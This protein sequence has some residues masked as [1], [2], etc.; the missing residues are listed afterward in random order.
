MPRVHRKRESNN[1]DLRGKDTLV[2][3]LGASWCPYCVYN[4]TQQRYECV[5]HRMCVYK[6]S[7][8]DYWKRESV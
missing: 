4:K 2:K 8:R 1:D 3:I 7:Y 6:R 5:Q